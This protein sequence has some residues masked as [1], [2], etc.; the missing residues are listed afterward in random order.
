MRRREFI[1][2]LGGA[3][4]LVRSFAALYSIDLGVNIDPLVTMRVDLPASTYPGPDDRRAFVASL[5][6]RLVA[7]PGVQAAAITTGVP[8]RD[9]G[10]RYLEIEGTP[11]DAQRGG[12]LYEGRC[13]ACHSLDASRVGP[14]HRGVFGRRA[15]AVKDYDY[16]PALK[17]AGSCWR[18]EPPMSEDPRLDTERPAPDQGQRQAHRESDD[19]VEHRRDG[20]RFQIAVVL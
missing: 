4:L 3:G 6:P 15:G 13:I 12:Q 5:E 19:D 18:S 1:A 14:Q 20:Y 8:S 11:G 10:E 2:L 17:K 9:G 7:I 16:S